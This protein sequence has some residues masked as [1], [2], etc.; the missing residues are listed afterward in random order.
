MKKGDSDSDVDEDTRSSS[1]VKNQSDKG[2]VVESFDWDEKSLSSEDEGVTSVKAFM[3]I[4]E[5]EPTVG[6]TAV[7]SGQWV[8]IT[9]KKDYLKKSV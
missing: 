5:D 4:A 6:K 3:D 1:C 9:M 8:E 7:R 2:L